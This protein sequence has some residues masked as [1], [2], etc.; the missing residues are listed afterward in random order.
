[1]ATSQK[2][3]VC[4]LF[5]GI[6][7]EHDISQRSADTVINALDREKYDVILVGITKDGRWLRYRGDVKDIYHGEWVT[8][9]VTPCTASASTD[10]HG[11]IEYHADGT[12][13]TQNVDVWVPCLH[14][15][16][17][18]DGTIQG[19]LELTGI[20]YVGCGVLASALCMDKAT[21]YGM[22]EEVG[23]RCPK[24]RTTIGVPSDDELQA[25]GDYL[26]FPIFVKPANGGSSIGVSKV[27]SP[28]ELRAAAQLAG[29]LDSKVLYESFVKG[30]EI[31]CGVMGHRGGELET[32]TPDELWVKSGMA[33]LHQEKN[34]GSG[35]ENTVISCPPDHADEQDIAHLKDAAM[36]I[37]RALGCEG[38]ARV[39]MFLTPEKEVV[40]NEVNTFPGMTYYSRFPRQM[41]A[42]GREIPDV[43]DELIRMAV[44]NK[45]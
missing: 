18:E 36:K 31:S 23:V 25:I 11:L 44:E 42:A 39:D 45:A 41:R 35:E 4:V 12:Y 10:V 13:V 19:L 28:E 29:S 32:G 16:G 22:V 8:H 40:F 20:P 27:E 1:M 2:M 21:T 34:P 30:V 5:G 24:S 3:D 43:M 33:H 26:G 15:I 14:G 17:G 9:D 37:Y 7:T 6:S 38:F